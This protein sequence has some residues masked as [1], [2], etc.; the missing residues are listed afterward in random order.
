MS[1]LKIVP[2]SVQRAAVLVGLAAVICAAS[3]VR[4]QQTLPQTQPQ[5]PAAPAQESDPFKFQNDTPV[6]LILSMTPEAGVEF[7]ATMAK[8]KEVLAKSTKPERK[9]QAAHWK[10]TKA[11]VPQG[12]NVMYMF[13][14]DAVV[15]DVT[16]S[17]FVILTEGGVPAADVTAMYNK[18]VPGLKGLNFL[19]YKTLIDMNGGN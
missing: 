3:S 14:L 18:V 16:Y 13:A 9:Q 1:V 11:E 10:V 15:K 5:Q 4:A 12:G 2:A 7:E 17:P 8:V 6:L 19:P